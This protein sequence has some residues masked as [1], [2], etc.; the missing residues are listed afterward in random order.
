MSGQNG[1]GPVLLSG[2]YA[3][4]TESRTGAQ[5]TVTQAFDTRAGR[6]V[7]IKRVLFGPTDERARDSFQREVAVLQDLRH[8]NIVQL[9]DVDRDEA[10]DWYLV[11]EWIP[12]TLHDVI[13]RDGALTWS[14]FWNRFG[15]PL[16]DGVVHAQKMRV[17]HRDIKPRNILVT[18]AGT[19]KL[20]DYGIAKL[21]DTA[22]AWAV[23]AGHTFRFNHTPGYTPQEPDQPEYSLSRDCYAFA[24]VAVSSVRR[25]RPR[26]P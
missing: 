7:A 12:Q 13:V 22:S 8:P 5:A 10:G 18:D 23:V 24:A 14:E 2:R 9:L 16:L 11:L 19:P 3:L 21:L 6:L 25:P 20:A 4:G 15:S 26:Q 17:A 1:A